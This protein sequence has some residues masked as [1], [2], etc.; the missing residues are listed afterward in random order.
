MSTCHL[1]PMSWSVVSTGHAGIPDDYEPQLHVVLG[2]PESTESDG[3]LLYP[4]R[5]AW[6]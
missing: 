4:N 5:V 6:I 1:L 2:H 3:R